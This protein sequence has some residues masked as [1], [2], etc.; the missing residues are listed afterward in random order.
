MN[1]KPSPRTRSRAR[2]FF[3]AYDNGKYSIALTTTTLVAAG[4]LLVY[5]GMLTAI[6]FS[7]AFILIGRH[8]SSKVEADY[9]AELAQD[10]QKVPAQE[11]MGILAGLTDQQRQKIKEII[12]NDSD[13]KRAS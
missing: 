7:L 10:L 6:A 12:H 4:L 8:L 3:N 9:I 5:F 2:R 11:R 1:N 13:S